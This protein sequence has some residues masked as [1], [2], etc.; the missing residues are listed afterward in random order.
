[1]PEDKL[2]EKNAAAAELLNQSH[3]IAAKMREAGFECYRETPF[4]LV[5][6]YL[7]SRQIESLPNFRRTCFIPYVAQCIRAPMLSALE[8]FLEKNPFCRFWTFSSGLRV[9]LSMIRD[10][11]DWMH[12][13]LK[14]LNAQPFMKAAGVRMVFR[15]TELGTPET[16]ANGDTLDGGEIERAADGQLYFHVHAH[17]VVELTK[18]FIAPKQWSALVGKVG[19][20]W[21]AWWGEGGAIRNARECCKYVT[22]PGEMLKLDGGELVALQEQLF[23]AK[24]VHPMGSLAAEIKQRKEEKKR[25]VKKRT[26][27]GRVYYAVKDW[28]KH[29]RRT[30]L[31]ANADAAAKLVPIPARGA[32][33]VVSRG[34]PRFGAAGVAEPVATV[35]FMRGSWNEATVRA[36]PLIAPVITATVHE[37]FAGVAI[38]VHTRTSTVGPSPA[39]RPLQPR[40]KPRAHRMS[41]ATAGF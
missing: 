35:M 5:R 28:N 33:R 11:T 18:G 8:F 6:Y 1:M 27:D 23:R 2:R 4:D 20:F 40:G 3:A 17:V 32:V 22:K 34:L 41:A 12:A 21:P 16:N 24:L 31:E 38:R 26:P 30:R 36:H 13:K 19:A 14:E 29:A 10:R 25:L 15:S 39:P 7:H 9:R 37:Y